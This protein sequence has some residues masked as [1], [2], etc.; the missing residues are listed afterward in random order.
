MFSD[1]LTLP[2]PSP[3]LVVEDFGSYLGKHSERLQIK[4]KGNVIREAP[5]V[6]LRQVII[7]ARSASVSTDAIR[8]CCEHGIPISFLSGGGKP[9]A[10]IDSP[11]LLGTIRT[12]RE[13]L[14]AYMDERAVMFAQATI[15]AKL[16]NQHNLLRYMAKYRKTTDHDLYLTIIDAAIEIGHLAD[17]VSKLSDTSIEDLRPKVMALEAHAGK[18]YWSA[19]ASLLVTVP[20]WVGR[21]HRGATD[22]VNA[23][24]NYG[25]GI[26]YGQIEAAL[27]LAGLDPYAGF[28]HAD[29]SGKPS[30]V[31]DLIEEFRQPVVD[32][33]I[34]ALLNR[35]EPIQMVDGK[36]DDASRSL[37]AKRVLARLETAE[38]YHKRRHKLRAII[39]LQAQRAASFFRS[40]GDYAG[41]IMR[42]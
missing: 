9:Y 5:L 28:V 38:P 30:M 21:V 34:F 36:L 1:I 18:R 25:Y 14:L 6:H 10:R 41:Y 17:E 32:R 22:I 26:L 16:W 11:A 13:Q 4:V 19:V 35:S 42:W 37:V 27:I 7:T 31:L 12:R 24:L 40:E 3:I 29:R 39:A 23:C 2:D 20:E 8:A 15:A 33:A